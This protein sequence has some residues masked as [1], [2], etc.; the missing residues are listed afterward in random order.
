[1]NS[2]T[3]RRR[4]RR[5]CVILGAAIAG[6]AFVIA[7]LIQPV[8]PRLIYNASA[9]APLGFYRVLSAVPLHRGDL[10]LVR[11]PASVRAL[12][13]ERGYIPATVPL[14]K[15]VAALAGDTVCVSG[16]TV[17][18]ND[19]PVA[20]QLAADHVGRPLPAWSGCRPL[21]AGE[22]FLLMADVPAS[23][24]SRYFGPVPA[25]SVIGRLVRP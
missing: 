18:I 10:V 17:F 7:S 1:M 2:P 14:V 20:R 16:R 8:T 3:L 22:L 24:D 21:A 9:S 11:T 5:R 25:T 23:F 13:A 4:H 6:A 15:R 19:Q 12:A